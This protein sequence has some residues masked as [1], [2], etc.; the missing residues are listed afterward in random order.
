MAAITCLRHTNDSRVVPLRANPLF[1]LLSTWAYP[2]RGVILDYSTMFS[3][4]ELC[5]HLSK[6]N[7]ERK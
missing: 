4:E 1:L 6:G 3:K 5:L 7:N 2:S